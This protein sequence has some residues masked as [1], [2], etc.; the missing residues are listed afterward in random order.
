M[1]GLAF[2][3]TVFPYNTVV[4][5]FD[6]TTHL[7]ADITSAGSHMVSGLFNPM[8][9]A[10]V[11]VFDVSGSGSYC[12]TLSGS[13]TLSGSETGVHYQLK[14]NGFN[15]GAE[16]TGTGSV[17]T[18]TGCEAGTYT[19]SARRTGTYITG[20]MNGSAV[21]TADPPAIGGSV[22]G[23]TT[24]TLGAATDTLRLNGQFGYVINWQKQ[25]D[26]GGYTD[27]PAT[28]GLEAYFETPSA[29][30]TWEYRAVVV[31]G[32]C[33]PEYAAPAIV[34]VS[35]GPV[36]RTWTGAFNEKWNIYGN[37]SPAGV[38]GAQDDVL[39]PASAPNMPVVRVE[40]F[41][42]NDVLVKAGASLTI[43]PG[44]IL[45]VNGTMTLEE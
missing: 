26:A 44:I 24:I 17:L 43:I 30:G 21:I 11:A 15:Y 1:P 22:A 36:M 35:S 27:I 7:L 2:N 45:T 5:A 13:T 16:L 23:G 31:N 42:C 20:N 32:S 33:P 18:W 4:S 28:A 10:P 14:K 40:G 41:S 9:N 8:L 12:A 19:V 25:V 38:P 39:I 3:F 37:W 6:R 34:I 29:T